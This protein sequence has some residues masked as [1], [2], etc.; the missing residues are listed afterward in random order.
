MGILTII[1]LIFG[2]I[3]IYFLMSVVCNSV[4]EGISAVFGIR[5]VLLTKWIKQTFPFAF[6][7]I[8]DAPAIDGLSKKGKTTNYISSANFSLIVM[9]IFTNY[10]KKV[11]ATV[12]DINLALDDFNSLLN[13]DTSS[14]NILSQDIQNMLRIFAAQAQI[15]SKDPGEQMKAFTTSL[16]NW[17]NS[18]MD[19]LS[20]VYKRWSMIATFIVASAITIALNMDSISLVKY[21]I[22]NPAALQTLDNAADSVAKSKSVQQNV[23]QISKGENSTTT[24]RT[25]DSAGVRFVITTVQSKVIQA[26]DAKS[27]LSSLVP[28]GWESQAVNNANWKYIMSKI[29]GL[30]ITIFAVNLGSPFWYDL[31]CKVANLRSSIKPDKSSS[32]TN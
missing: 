25:N 11:P 8:L 3:F 27:E 13:P 28:I 29:I 19:R 20:G 23:A 4:F 31:L 26:N 22:A 18:M 16:E 5:A 10:W 15:S 7:Q 9:N 30:L 17:F 21:L 32:T 24:T 6:M 12:Q 14:R 1:N 2:M